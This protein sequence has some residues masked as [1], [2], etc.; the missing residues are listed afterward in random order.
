MPEEIPID[1][2]DRVEEI[3]RGFTVQYLSRGEW[4]NEDRWEYVCQFDRANN[5]AVFPRWIADLLVKALQESGR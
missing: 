5:C 3:G 4:R 1:H 2:S